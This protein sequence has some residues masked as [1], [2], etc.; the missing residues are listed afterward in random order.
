MVMIS[1]CGGGSSSPAPGPST[2]TPTSSTTGSAAKTCEDLIGVG[3]PVLADTVNN[4]C[5]MADGSASVFTSHG[6]GAAP[7]VNVFNDKFYGVVGG[8]WKAGDT[9]ASMVGC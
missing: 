5:D 7:E 9:A 3:K 2:P 6:C 1:G 8:T 4:G